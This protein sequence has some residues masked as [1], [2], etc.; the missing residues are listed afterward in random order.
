MTF[1]MPNKKKN[2]RLFVLV[3]FNFKSSKFF[4]YSILYSKELTAAAGVSGL[5]ES[6]RVGSYPYSVDVG[7]DAESRPFLFS[8]LYA[9]SNRP[10]PR[11]ITPNVTL[12]HH[13]GITFILISFRINFRK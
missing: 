5:P 4:I 3:R 11:P 2:N 8:T 10:E 6:P 9:Q 7:C 1:L 13:A 12:Y